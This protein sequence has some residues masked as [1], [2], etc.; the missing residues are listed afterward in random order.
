MMSA[1]RRN[2]FIIS[3]WQNDFSFLSDFLCLWELILLLK[4]RNWTSFFSTSPSLSLFLRF[5]LVPHIAY[6][7]SCIP[8]SDSGS[9]L[10]MYKMDV[11]LASTQAIV[12]LP[13]ASGFYS[14]YISE[15]EHFPRRVLLYPFP[16]YLITRRPWRNSPPDKPLA[17][18]RAQLKFMVFHLRY[19]FK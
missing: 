5:M 8:E 10:L 12:F 6:D 14:S 2:N 18:C 17:S 15:R 4:W 13:A 9:A 16:P 19:N 11:T 3:F 1:R 7:F